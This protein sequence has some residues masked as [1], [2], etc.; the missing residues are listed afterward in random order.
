LNIGVE[1]DAV[2]EHLVEV[3]LA[4]HGAQCGLRK[5]ARRLV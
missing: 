3:V 4:Q 1:F 2:S 5:L